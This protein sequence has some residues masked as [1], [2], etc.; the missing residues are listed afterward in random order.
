M[1]F[2]FSYCDNGTFDLQFLGGGVLNYGCVQEEIRFMI[3]PELLCSRLFT[4]VLDDNECLLIMGCERFSKY[5]GY[6]STFTWTGD[7]LDLTPFDSFNRRKC[8]IVA[9]DA[10]LFKH[11]AAQYS[12]EML[13]RELNKV[14]ASTKQPM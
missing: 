4:E 11:K 6:A 3:C 13:L 9:I 5:T 2:F 8:S 1:F 10:I 7:Y 12:D 14:N